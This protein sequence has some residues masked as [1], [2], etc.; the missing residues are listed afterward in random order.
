M[1]LLQKYFNI[2]NIKFIIG[3]NIVQRIMFLLRITSLIA[4]T[5]LWYTQS[6]N[7]FIFTLTS[8]ICILL[9]LPVSHPLY[10]NYL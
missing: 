7:S 2:T 4:V 5:Q 10:I 6:Q 9:K 3:K 1:N 8:I